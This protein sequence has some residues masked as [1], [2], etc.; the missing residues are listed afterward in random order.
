MVGFDNISLADNQAYS[1]TTYEQPIDEIIKAAINQM[2]IW[3]ERSAE[4]T[5][6]KLPGKLV[7][8][9]SS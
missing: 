4:V 6:V 7:I 5:S 1:I 8:R 3:L 9:R 2:K